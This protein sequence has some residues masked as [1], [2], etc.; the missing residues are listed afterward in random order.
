MKVH[1]QGRSKKIFQMRKIFFLLLLFIFAP[2]TNLITSFSFAAE[3]LQAESEV[4]TAQGVVAYDEHQ[5]DEALRLLTQARSINPQN[6]KTLYYLGLTHLALKQPGEAV[7]ALEAARQLQP[8]DPAIERQL[9]V[10][11]FTAGRYDEATPLLEHAFTAEP[12][13]ENLGYYVG[14]GRYRQKNYKGAIE[15][16]NATKTSDP[17]VQQLVRFYRGLA[18][19]VLG[20]PE[21]ASAELRQLQTDTNLPFT[22][23]AMQIQQAM[24]GRKVEEGKRLNLQIS[25]GGYYNDNVAINPRNSGT[26]PDPQTNA[27]LYGLYSR[28]TTS[29]GVIATLATDYAFF[30]QGGFEGDVSYSFLQTVNTNSAVNDFNMQSH[31]PGLSGFYRS[32]IAELP[33]QLGAQYTYNYIFLGGAGFMSTH[34]P[35]LTATIVPPSFGSVGNLTSVITRWQKKEFYREPADGTDLRFSSEGRDGYN[36]MAGLIHAFRFAQDKHILR[37]GFQYDD[38]STAGGSFSYKGYRGQAGLQYTLPIADLIFRYDYDIHFR[39]YKNVQAFFTDFSGALVKREDT[40]HTHLVQLIYPIT[41]HWSVTAQ[42]QGML[43]KS[44]I[45][46][47]DFRQNVW[48]GLITWIY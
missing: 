36:V 42:Y 4:L 43:N 15:A 25:V 27:I 1:R 24:A 5:Y 48:T 29:P 46:V 28:S 37:F 12:T 11:Y 21:L 10:A 7:T 16:F 18:L 26:T 47:Y 17:N 6:P 40:Q 33:F 2:A 3:A 35:T 30:R 31:L 19:G 38:E 14:L 20:M 9:G 45:P 34:S 13:S 22:G 32:T 23:Q 39:N 44:N 8:S 41:Q